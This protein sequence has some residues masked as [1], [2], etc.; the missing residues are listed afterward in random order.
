MNR[1]YLI[2]NIARIVVDTDTGNKLYAN[3][4]ALVLRE[5][6]EPTGPRFLARAF[7]VEAS[8]EIFQ[9]RIPDIE[10]TLTQEAPPSWIPAGSTMLSTH[11]LLSIDSTMTERRVD[12]TL[13]CASMDGRPIDVDLLEQRDDPD[14]PTF[15]RRIWSE[16]ERKALLYWTAPFISY[17]GQHN[18]D[19]L[20]ARGGRR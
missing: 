3:A 20:R 8:A 9:M 16:L 15:L 18:A 10:H 1:C 6:D 5:S 19:A 4:S 12:L 14:I 11:A 17:R 2:T 7:G 13:D